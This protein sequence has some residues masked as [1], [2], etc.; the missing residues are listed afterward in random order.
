MNFCY[1]I[2]KFVVVHTYYF[3]QVYSPKFRKGEKYT[4]EF[5]INVTKDICP[6]K[7]LCFDYFILPDVE[8]GDVEFRK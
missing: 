7:G 2:S 3:K 5:F 8:V 1:Y 4:T 6:L